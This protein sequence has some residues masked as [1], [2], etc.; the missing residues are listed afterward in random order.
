M[1]NLKELKALVLNESKD[2]KHIEYEVRNLKDLTKLIYLDDIVTESNLSN[3]ID[4]KNYKIILRFEPSN[5]EEVTIAKELEF[6]SLIK[7]IFN[8]FRADIKRPIFKTNAQKR[9]KG[10]Q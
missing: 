8:L 5:P 3:I 9:S 4:L 7:K 1:A 10:N 2:Y 6:D